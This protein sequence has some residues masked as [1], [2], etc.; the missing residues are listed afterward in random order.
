MTVLVNFVVQASST[1]LKMCDVSHTLA[2]MA[3][4]A[5]FADFDDFTGDILFR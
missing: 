1:V 5:D 4:F 2:R 3:D